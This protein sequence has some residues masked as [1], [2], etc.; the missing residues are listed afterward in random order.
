[1]LKKQRKFIEPYLE[2]IEALEKEIKE[3][4]M[5]YLKSFDDLRFADGDHEEECRLLDEADV[6]LNRAQGGA[7]DAIPLIKAALSQ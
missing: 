3:L 5:A 4:R 7:Y 6:C 1:M 2:K